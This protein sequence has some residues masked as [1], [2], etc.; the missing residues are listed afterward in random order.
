MK[1]VTPQGQGGRIRQHS[2]LD[3]EQAKKKRKEKK[4]K[5][6]QNLKVTLLNTFFYT[7]LNVYTADNLKQ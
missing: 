5:T 2:A 7:P 6:G 4:R 3:D 1:A